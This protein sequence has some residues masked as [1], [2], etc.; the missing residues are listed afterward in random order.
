[1]DAWER[2]NT[3]MVGFVGYFA[4]FFFSLPLYPSPL[5]SV[6]F[7]SV[8]PSLCPSLP[9]FSFILDFFFLSI[10]R[11]DFPYFNCLISFSPL[12]FPL[13]TLR[14]HHHYDALRI[15]VVGGVEGEERVL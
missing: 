14:P 3:G 5:F 8:P 2:T 9:P 11:L 15:V 4:F 13:G 6:P 1:M 7:P 12:I 10:Y